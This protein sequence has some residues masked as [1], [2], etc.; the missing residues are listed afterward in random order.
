[1]TVSNTA[2][3]SGT[4][5]NQTAT[6]KTTTK[7]E[8]EQ[9]TDKA[10]KGLGDNFNTFLKMLTTQLK[11]QDPTKPMDTNEMTQ[12]L[13]QF[14]SVE[15]TIGTNSRLDKLLKIQQANM[16][17]SN[18]G[19]L[20]RTVSFEGDQFELRENTGPTPL[21]YELETA[22]KRVEIKILDKNGNT[23][24][25]LTGDTAVG[26]HKIDWDYKDAAGEVVPPGAYS[27]NVTP[28]AKDDKTFIIAKT[29]TFGTVSG[30]G[31]ADG[32]TTLSVYGK[33]IPLSQIQ[34]VH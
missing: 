19:Y 2:A 7:T 18:L 6:G 13:V 1:M 17:S 5:W 4:P 33:E 22:A 9:A 3:A 32:E 15:Q 34:A 31:S 24:R 23:V 27:I 26:K 12:Q 30:I 28:V 25:T 8:S 14:A 11:N 10:T 20:G 21:G 29:Y 16:V